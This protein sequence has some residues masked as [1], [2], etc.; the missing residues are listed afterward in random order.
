MDDIIFDENKNIP[1]I[2]LN[3]VDE[4]Y[5]D[6]GKKLLKF[7]DLNNNKPVMLDISN[8]NMSVKEI[9]ESIQKGSYSFNSDD[10]IYNTSG[11]L[12]VQKKYSKHELRIVPVDKISQ[13]RP[14]IPD[15]KLKIVSLFEKNK[16]KFNPNIKYICV[17]DDLALD[18]DNRVIACSFDDIKK[19]YDVRYADTTKYEKENKIVNESNQI[20]TD[21]DDYDLAVE[22]LLIYNK[23]VLVSGYSIDIDRLIQYSADPELL[24]GQTMSDKEKMVWNKIINI[25]LKKKNVKH[26]KPKVKTLTSKNRANAFT[27]SSLNIFTSGVTVGLVM[28]FLIYMIIKL[29]F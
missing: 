21:N 17:F 7:I 24:E 16:D 23:P 13:I 28:S 19:Q 14:Y 26:D 4:V 3:S 20:N 15:N 8:D 12:D 27:S 29:L 11:I 9:I 1:S 6:D 25:Y 5:L 22:Q 18:E 10:A 2:D